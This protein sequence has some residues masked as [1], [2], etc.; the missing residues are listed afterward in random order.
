MRRKLTNPPTHEKHFS[1]A[2]RHFITERGPDGRRLDMPV[3]KPDQS[4][5]VS[6]FFATSMSSSVRPP[7]SCVVRRSVIVHQRMST[8]GW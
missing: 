5:S 2:M 7:T 1:R 4:T 8:S 3:T 6:I